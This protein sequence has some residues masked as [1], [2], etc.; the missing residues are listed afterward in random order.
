ML[1]PLNSSSNF[2]FHLPFTLPGGIGGARDA[3]GAL[4]EFAVLPGCEYAGVPDTRPDARTPAAISGRAALSIAFLPNCLMALP[5]V[6][7]RFRRERLISAW[8]PLASFCK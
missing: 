3:L 8:L 2:S 4:A 7:R 6:L 5:S 1:V